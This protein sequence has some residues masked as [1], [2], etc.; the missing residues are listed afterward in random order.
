MEIV[1]VQGVQAEVARTLFARM[2]GLIGRSGLPPGAG[3]LILKC[4][5]SGPQ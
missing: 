1:E 3:L 2:R 5:L 4:G